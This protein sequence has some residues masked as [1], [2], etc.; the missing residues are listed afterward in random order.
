M[1]KKLY[2][3]SAIAAVLMSASLASCNHEEADIFDQNAAHRTEEARKMYKEILLD[4]GGKWQMEYFTT[5]EEHGYVYLFTFRNDGTV[6][7]SGNNEYIT[8][9]TNID[10]NVPSYGS[11]T[12]MW[13]ILSDN[14]PVLSFNSYN[15]IFHLFATPEDIPGTE[16]DEQGYGHS[17]DYEFDLMKF[18]ND[19]LYLEGKKNGAE[20]IMTRIAP[21]I[22]DETYLNEVVALADSF[23]NAK[24]PAVYVNLPGGYRHVVLDGATQLPKFYP[25]TGDYITEYVGRNAIITHDGFTLGKPLTL[26]DSIDGNDYTIQHFIRQKDG[27][28][29]CTDDNRITITADA[30][31]KVVGDE[32][33]LWRVNAADCKGELGTA[34]AGLNTGFK[35]YNGSSLVHFNIGLNV[36]NNTKSPYTMVVRIKTKRGSYLNM[37][38]PYTVEYIGKDEIKFVLGEMDSNMKTFIDK[39]PAFK[40]MMNK[41]ASSTFKCSSNSLIAPVNMV[42]TDSSDASSALGISIQ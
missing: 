33:L 39:V 21:E 7:I 26:R 37:S 16:R 22:D 2:K 5:E 23:F 40:T 6:T 4:K 32:R 13:T 34:F 12:S 30:L 15:T 9:L 20:I 18:S 27:S 42:L 3:F 35:A 29:L 11:E 38:V 24:V 14:G 36:L 10:S 8:K 1:M 28:L 17:G 25:E 19:T 41:L 31:N